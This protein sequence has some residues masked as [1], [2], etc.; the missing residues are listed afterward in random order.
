ME[1]TEIV[2]LREVSQTQKDEH[3]T[4]SL[5]SRPKML[6]SLYVYLSVGWYSRKGTVRRER[7]LNGGGKERW[8]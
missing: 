4:L 7:D 2:I 8:Y 6:I 1:A 3:Y 5:T